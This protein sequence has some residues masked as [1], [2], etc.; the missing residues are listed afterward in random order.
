MA[1]ISSGRPTWVVPCDD[2][3]NV[4]ASSRV[5]PR[6]RITR[7]TLRV[8]R[9]VAINPG[10]VA[11]TR[12]P[13]CMSI[14]AIALVKFSKATLTDPPMVNSADPARDP[15]PAIF[16]MLPLTV[17][18]C[19]HTARRH[20]DIAVKFQRE[21][22]LPVFFCQGEEVRPFCRPGIVH[23]QVE[24]PKCPTATATARAGASGSRRLARNTC[25]E[26]PVY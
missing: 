2:T 1:P 23:Q 17:R 16:T 26:T 19:G 3:R 13:C 20:P 14:S 18:K 15:M 5:K 4:G 6:S 21:S 24:R 10:L 9:S 11:L 22:V 8:Q 25:V 12:T 7:S